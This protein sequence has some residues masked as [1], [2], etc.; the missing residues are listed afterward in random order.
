MLALDHRGEIGRAAGFERVV[1]SCMV[2]V[3]RRQALSL[4]YN[5][6]NVSYFQS[7]TYEARS[8][9]RRE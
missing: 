1:R 8:K 4:Y 2:G 7:D 3:L 6:R 9:F 5:W